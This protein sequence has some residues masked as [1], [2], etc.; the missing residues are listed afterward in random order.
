MT[1]VLALTPVAAWAAEGPVRGA[2]RVDARY[3]VT[4]KLPGSGWQ[5]VT[6]SMQLAQGAVTPKG[7][8]TTA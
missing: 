5:Q 8:Y 1:G 3:H 2:D 4:F 6:G 7:P